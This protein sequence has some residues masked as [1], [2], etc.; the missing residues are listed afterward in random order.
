MVVVVV[1][2]VGYEEEKRQIEDCLLFPLL[3]PEV[4]DEMARAT[5]K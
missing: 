4:Y 1:M 5:R 3:R 2:A